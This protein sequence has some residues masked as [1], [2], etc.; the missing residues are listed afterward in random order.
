MWAI[1]ST[2]LLLDA[3]ST[4]LLVAYQFY[5]VYLM[6]M[7]FICRAN[8]MQPMGVSALVGFLAFGG[9]IPLFANGLLADIYP[10][11]TE[12]LLKVLGVFALSQIAFALGTLFKID[13][14][15]SPVHM[16]LHTKKVARNIT[17]MHFF[18]L[19][20][21]VIAAGAFRLKFNIGAA[22]AIS[23]IPYSG[24][25]HY[26][27]LDGL[28]VV[29]LWFLAASLKKKNLGY[30]VLAGV[31][32]MGLV[33]TQALLGWRGMIFRVVICVVVVFWFQKRL[34]HNERVRSFGWLIVLAMVG[35]FTIQLGH[36]TRA[37]KMKAE[38][39]FSSSMTGFVDKILVRSQ[40][41]TRLAE[42]VNRFDKNPLTNDWFF[43]RLRQTRE[44]A[45]NYVDRTVYGVKSHQKHSVGCSGPG[46][47]YLSA[48]LIGVGIVY[49]LW[50]IF[51]GNVY[52]QIGFEK[53]T[54]PNLIAIALYA[55]M[56]DLLQYTNAENFDIGVLK[57]LAAVLAILY[58]SKI[59]V[60]T[61]SKKKKNWRQPVRVADPRSA[62]LR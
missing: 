50:G 36:Q 16:L 31:S 7:A 18:M 34:Y 24:Y 2:K 9:N 39:N 5:L 55:Q 32:L 10:I 23:P 1:Y 33:V 21:F 25:F 12:L 19:I 47:V 35:F 27:L 29:L 61:G 58:F 40:G 59:F 22:K 52:S 43:L 38:E 48:G 56:I 15:F 44:T 26:G 4:P 45:T 17:G 6:V 30:T 37:R 62:F 53:S 57:K 49:F 41:T 28:L 14:R 54:P 11:D 3:G 8:I 51:Y 42:V 46:A 20:L 13:R 60:F